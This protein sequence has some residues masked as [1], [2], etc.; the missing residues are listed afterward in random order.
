MNDKALKLARPPIVEAVL[1]I[2][3]DMPPGL[4]IGALEQPARAAF[5]KD[6]P[7]VRTVFLKEHLIEQPVDGPPN[8]K[9]RRGIQ[10]FQFVREDG[11][12]L[13][14]VRGQGYSFNR[15][16]PY[17]ALDDLAH[18]DALPPPV[19]GDDRHGLGVDGKPRASATML[20]PAYPS[21]V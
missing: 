18:V 19:V 9:A 10:A 5:A 17:S 11:T 12:Q 16:T 3:C 15:L 1:D 7:E 14:Q 4:D 6:Y 2:D 8:V 13:V 21:G 20:C